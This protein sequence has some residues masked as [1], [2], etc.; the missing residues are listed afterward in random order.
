MLLGILFVGLLLYLF[1]CFC[2]KRICEKCGQ[3]PGI[4]IW[5]PIVNIIPL[6]Q[7]AGMAV[8]MIVLFFIPFVNFIV[9]IM[10]WV[11]ICTARRKSPV[12][13]IGVILLPIVFI[14]YLA[15]SE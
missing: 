13:V 14:P 9:S 5:I 6:L 1:F 10:M 15:F 8:W 12:V 4:L 7:A 11:K 3:N 2:C